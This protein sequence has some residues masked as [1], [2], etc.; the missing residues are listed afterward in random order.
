MENDIKF[1]R[2]PICPLVDEFLYIMIDDIRIKHLRYWIYIIRNKVSR[3]IVDELW[4]RLYEY[5][6]LLKHYSGKRSGI[7][8][9]LNFLCFEYDD[10]GDYELVK[11]IHEVFLKERLYK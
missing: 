9:L 7:L 11:V 10:D 1:N 6:G 8:I 4:E 5:S 2:E 3:K